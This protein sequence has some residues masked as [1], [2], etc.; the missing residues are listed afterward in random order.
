[1]CGR[2]VGNRPEPGP[3]LYSFC[4]RLPR[5]TGRELMGQE[6]SLSLTKLSMQ[7]PLLRV[8]RALAAHTHSGVP[9]APQRSECWG[10]QKRTVLA[11]G[12]SFRQKELVSQSCP[13]PRLCL[14]LVAWD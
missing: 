12:V 14:L 4:S 1:M 13:C 7:V 6:G 5:A 8:P 11:N 2:E 3:H 10:E 9:P